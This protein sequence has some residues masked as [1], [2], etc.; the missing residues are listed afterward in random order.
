[1]R[2]S[3][4]TPCHCEYLVTVYFNFYFCI[5][6]FSVVTFMEKI[7]FICPVFTTA[8]TSL[9]PSQAPSHT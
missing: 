7:V 9:I 5:V 3:G 4:K 6:Y 8:I 1:M 2:N